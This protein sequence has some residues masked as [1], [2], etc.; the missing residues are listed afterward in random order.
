[1]STNYDP[2]VGFHFKVEFDLNGITQN[3]F[4]F[5]EVSGL[6]LEMEEET[7][8]E[9][10]ENRFVQKLPVRAKYSDL[11]LKR[12]MLNDSVV[13]KWCQQA[14]QNYDIEPVTIRVKLLNEEHM[15]LKTYIFVNAWPKKWSI[16]DLNAGTSEIIIET[17][18]L[19]YQYFEIR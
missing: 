1:M 13:F 10:G 7:V 15:P 9:G 14:I 3:D 6:S 11:V 4:R 18:E 2:P 17:L 16:S 8:V 19:A 5:Q 12:G